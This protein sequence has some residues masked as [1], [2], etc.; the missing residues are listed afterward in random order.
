MWY[1]FGIKNLFS[2]E[3]FI[4]M[5]G[6]LMLCSYMNIIWGAQLNK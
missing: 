6:K 4:T 1:K 2:Q 3:P 5:T